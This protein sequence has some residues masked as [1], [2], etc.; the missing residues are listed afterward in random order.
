M[1]RFKDEYIPSAVLGYPARVAP[2][3]STDLAQSDSGSEQANRNWT[4]PLR[5]VSIPEGVRDQATF[6]SLKAHWLV[7]G[8][9]AHTFPFRDPT[10]FASVA[11]TRINHAPTLSRIDQPLSPGTGDGFNRTFQLIKRYTVGS[12]TYDRTIY[13]PVVSSILLGVNGVDPSAASPALVATVTRYAGTVTF[14]IAP[15]PGDLLT[16]GGLFDIETRYEGDDVFDGIMRTF[17]VAGFADVPLQEV[18]FC[19]D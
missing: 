11:L 8:G 7:M 12:Q 4:N 10:D 16:W 15:D 9:P 1:T 19:V 18:R 14:D 6:E 3:F 5:S 17:G 13:L 2:R